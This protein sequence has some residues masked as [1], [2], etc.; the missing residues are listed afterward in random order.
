MKKIFNVWRIFGHNDWFWSWMWRR[1]VCGFLGVPKPAAKKFAPRY[2]VKQA[3]KPQ[4]QP[5][6]AAP[7]KP[8]PAP[9]VQPPLGFDELQITHNRGGLGD[10]LNRVAKMAANL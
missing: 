6:P 5:K 2:Q 10:I 3:P 9:I 7:P 4:P 1:E 8:Q